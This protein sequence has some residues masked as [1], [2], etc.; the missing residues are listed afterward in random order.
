MIRDSID[1][2]GNFRTAHVEYGFGGI[3][4]GLIVYTHRIIGSDHI[5]QRL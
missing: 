2:F 4:P 5:G 1:S 3:G